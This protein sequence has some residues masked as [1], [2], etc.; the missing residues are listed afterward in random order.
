MRDSPSPLDALRERVLGEHAVPATHDNI[1]GV[2][3]RI[4][5]SLSLVISIKYLT[6]FLRDGGELPGPADLSCQTRS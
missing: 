6:Y 5:W 2:V 1:L 3:S 4:L